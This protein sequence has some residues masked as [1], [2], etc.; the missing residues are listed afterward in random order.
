M[1]EKRWLVSSVPQAL[2][3][4]PLEPNEMSSCHFEEQ[5]FEQT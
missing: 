1:I 2:E 4:W 5:R 3:E